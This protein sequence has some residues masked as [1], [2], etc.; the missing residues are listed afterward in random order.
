MSKHMKLVKTTAPPRNPGINGRLEITLKRE[1]R[2]SRRNFG[3]QHVN[4]AMA[5]IHLGD[6]FVNQQRYKEA[7]TAF[8]QAG[9]I[10]EQLGVGHELLWAIA[11]RSLS[12]CLFAM[13]EYAEARAVTAQA[14]DLILS[15]Q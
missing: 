10:Y 11:L 14:T 13:E 4:V 5:L 3:I 1:L 7:S 8:R 9:S 15:Y 12:Q 6:F 2:T